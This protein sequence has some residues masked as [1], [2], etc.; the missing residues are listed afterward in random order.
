MLALAT[1]CGKQ[2]ASKAPNPTSAPAPKP[3][4]PAAPSSKPVKTALPTAG[5]LSWN[6]PAL[7][8]AQTPKSS[9]RAAEY[10]IDGQ[11][12]GDATLAV[13]HFGAGQGGDV[14]SNI[15][16]W[17]GQFQQPAGTKKN[18]KPTT[19]RQVVAGMQV[20]TVDVKGS[21]SE[22]AM[23]PHATSP[24]QPQTHQRLLGAIVEGPQGPVF[25]KLVGPQKTVNLADTAF[26]A[27]INS[28]HP[29]P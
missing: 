4:E 1:G 9:M 16:R 7:F 17:V 29:A 23:N 11:G 5:G 18:A 10:R 3:S 2:Q 25:F 14:Q 28:I 8:I 15:D 6:P 13:F 19:R 21:Y 27:L 22:M 20:T 26:A 24:A 12:Q